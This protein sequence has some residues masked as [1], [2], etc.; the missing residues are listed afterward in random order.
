[1]SACMLLA[2]GGAGLVGLC[3]SWTRISIGPSCL[4]AASGSYVTRTVPRQDQVVPPN[5]ETG[6]RSALCFSS[7]YHELLFDVELHALT[8]ELEA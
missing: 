1:M 7:S 4:E 3:P 6:C 2:R 8:N 5:V